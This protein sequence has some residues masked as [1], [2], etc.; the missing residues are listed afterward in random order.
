M[1]WDVFDV[2]SVGVLA[3]R[4][5]RVLGSVVADAGVRVSG[6]DV[7]G[8][9]ERERVVAGWNATSVVVPGVRRVGGVVRVAGGWGAGCG[10]VGCGGCQVTF[11]ELE[12]RANR[13][14]RRLVSSGCGSWV[15]WWVWWWSGRWR[16]WWRCWRVLKAGAAYVPVDPEYPVDR[17]L[18]VLEDAQ[19]GAGACLARLCWAWLEG[20]GRSDA[21]GR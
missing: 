15:A 6:V 20:L 16:W 8:E 5:V 9:A 14:A 13:L 7:L 3:G 10:G 18:F 19:V 21:A 12:V 17:A 1:R 2:G 4:F 11:G